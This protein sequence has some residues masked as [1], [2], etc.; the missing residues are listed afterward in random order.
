MGQDF[1]PD[2]VPEMC[3]HPEIGKDIEYFGWKKLV[4]KYV[5]RGA[6]VRIPQ[7]PQQMVNDGQLHINSTSCGMGGGESSAKADAA[8][9]RTPTHNYWGQDSTTV[10][11]MSGG[12][13]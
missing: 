3:F 4:Y 11:S 12:G 5:P 6:K 9:P 1:A 8:T 2:A 7:L 10:G 13:W